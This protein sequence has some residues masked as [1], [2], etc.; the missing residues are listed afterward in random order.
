M[1]PSN[2]TSEDSTVLSQRRKD[3]NVSDEGWL[4]FGPAVGLEDMAA[5]EAPSDPILADAA[6]EFAGAS[7]L[8]RSCSFAETHFGLVVH[9]C[10]APGAPA[11]WG[12]VHRVH[13]PGSLHYLHRAA[14][15]S[16]TEQAM[17]RFS[18]WTL[19][20]HTQDM[21]ELIH[22]PGASVKNGKVVPPLFWG[23]TT[24]EAHRNHVHFGI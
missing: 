7:L 24:W 10:D 21:A 2:T 23:S 5:A 18:D 1:A 16:G 13:A 20:K 19:R 9:E 11:R 22:N 3:L 6:A 17:R 8:V 14:D 15:I 4:D 12:P